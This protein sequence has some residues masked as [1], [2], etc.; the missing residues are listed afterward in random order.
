MFKFAEINCADG[1]NTYVCREVFNDPLVPSAALM[2]PGEGKRKKP[3][4]IKE[5][6]DKAFIEDK[7]SLFFDDA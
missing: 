6:D 3:R 4:F 1:Y 7:I 5:D 2:K